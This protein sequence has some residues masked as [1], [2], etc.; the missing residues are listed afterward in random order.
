[1]LQSPAAFA[2]HELLGSPGRVGHHKLAAGGVAVLRHRTRDVDIFDE[3]LVPPRAYDPP[4]AVA[5]RLA[6]LARLSVLDLGG[7]IGLFGL[8]CLRRY[9]GARITS[10]EADAANIQILRACRSR[11]PH[12]DWTIMPVAAGARAATVRFNAGE[13]ADSAVSPDGSVEVPVIDIF[14]LVA[15]ADFVKIDIEGS[16][17]PILLDDR[18]ASVT[19][20]VVALEW[21][22]R[23]APPGDAR[24][25]ILDRFADSGYVG[26]AEG[27]RH[28]GLAWAWRPR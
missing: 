6:A 26:S 3:V 21:H 7:N 24:A 23:G 13:F 15:N 5:E 25:T 16:E 10:L 19:A 28:H 18:F 9:P 11:N 2:A 12:A 22:E 20:R 1:V 27:N 14:P 17:W 4:P 8:D